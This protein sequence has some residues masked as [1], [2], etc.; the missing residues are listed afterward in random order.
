MDGVE[1][2]TVRVRALGRGHAVG[3]Q[4]AVGGGPT[5]GDDELGYVG[6]GSSSGS[7]S[8]GPL[9]REVARGGGDTASGVG[10]SRHPG[11][12]GTSALPSPGSSLASSERKS[13]AG[14][15]SGVDREYDDSHDDYGEQGGR[16]RASESGDEDE[17]EGARERRYR[18][19][20]LRSNEIDAVRSA[21]RR[22]V[23]SS[24]ED[25]SRYS[26]GQELE[27]TESSA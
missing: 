18:G 3:E 1:R 16:A 26:S 23:P 27:T 12:A 7:G 15:V 22:L 5:G 14:A 17:G 25:D 8:E 11:S 21:A 4:Q 13:G 6:E 24:D 2:F 19:M 9:S 10:G 20:G